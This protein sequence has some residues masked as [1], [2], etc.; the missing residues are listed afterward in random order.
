V[1]RRPEG[2]DWVPQIPRER[3]AG[4]DRRSVAGY[5]SAHRSFERGV[6]AK[7]AVNIPTARGRAR[8]RRGSPRSSCSRMAVIDWAP[9][10]PS[11]RTSALPR[12]GRL[13]PC[14]NS[15]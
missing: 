3:G 14:A 4:L 7:P 6:S 13:R 15:S 8:R 11:G 5:R 10:D 12:A 2:L 1:A 9:L